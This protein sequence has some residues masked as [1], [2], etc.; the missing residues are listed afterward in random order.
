MTSQTGQ[1]IIAIHILSSISRSNRNQKMNV[2]QLIEDNMKNIF[3]EQNVVEKLVPDP[4]IKIK[5]EHL[6]RSTV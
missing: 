2:G 6:S 3:L 4:F 5:T 1:Q